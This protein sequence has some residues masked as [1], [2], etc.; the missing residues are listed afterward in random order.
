MYDS[1][2]ENDSDEDPA[3]M[4]LSDGEYEEEDEDERGHWLLPFKFVGVVYT[5]K[6]FLFHHP[7]CGFSIQYSVS[8][9]LAI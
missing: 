7:L 8:L 6:V 1:D 5:Q 3:D 4:L 2:Y 9:N